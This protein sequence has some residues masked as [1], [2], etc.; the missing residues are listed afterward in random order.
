MRGG[1]IFR[2]NT[3]FFLS[4]F[5]SS[6]P[7][8]LFEMVNVTKIPRCSLLQVLLV[9]LSDCG[10]GEGG[11]ALVP[12]SHFAC[13]AE[14]ERAAEAHSCPT[15][16]ELN[17]SFVQRMRTLTEQVPLVGWMVCIVCVCGPFRMNSR[18]HDMPPR[19]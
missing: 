15:H 19:L 8:S 1:S 6:Y 17:R 4:S 9:L 18:Q 10:P 2:A 16:E 7:P 11:T 14:L 5:I 13:F 12:G 3:P